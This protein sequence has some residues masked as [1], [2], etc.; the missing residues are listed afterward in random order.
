MFDPLLP[1]CLAISV[2]APPRG[3]HATPVHQTE[4]SLRHYRVVRSQ[5]KLLHLLVEV[6][7]AASHTI[8]RYWSF[9]LSNPVVV[10]DDLRQLRQMEVEYNYA[11][12]SVEPA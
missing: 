10:T 5:L 6:H 9:A 12:P 11:P 7:W 3:R 8:V 4:Y 2:P 1:G